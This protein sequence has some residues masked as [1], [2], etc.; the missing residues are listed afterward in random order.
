MLNF[1]VISKMIERMFLRRRVELILPKEVADVGQNV[2]EAVSF[3]Y[4]FDIYT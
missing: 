3:I 4:R 2:A 1:F